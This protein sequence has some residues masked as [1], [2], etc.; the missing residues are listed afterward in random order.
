VSRPSFVILAGVVAL[1]IAQPAAA[2]EETRRRG[3]VQVIGQTY[4][5]NIDDDLAGD[6]YRD[7]FGGKRGW[8]FRGLASRALYAGVGSLEVGV[9]AGYFQDRGKGQLRDGGGDAQDDT[10]LHVLPASLSLTYRFD[11]LERRYRIPLMVYG[12]AS[13]ERFHWWVTDGGGDRR[14]SGATNGYSFTG[15]GG[16]LLDFFDR[17]MARELDRET[18]I[19][20]TWLTFDVTKSY[21][22]DFG[23]S[24]SW[25][26]SDEELSLGFGLLFAF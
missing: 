3:S 13:L 23:A 12:R 5:P 18:G 20:D 7:V 14:E 1:A 24:D 17:G 15:G 11:W 25:D 19:N 4:R 16:L 26:L 22:D 21:V 8:T 2:Q 9:G 6:P 10:Y